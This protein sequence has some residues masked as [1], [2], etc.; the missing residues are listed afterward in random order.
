[1][2]HVSNKMAS[3]CRSKTPNEL[4]IQCTCLIPVGVAVLLV[5]LDV[6][7]MVAVHEVYGV[8]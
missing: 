1:M 5:L 6:L 3:Q 4:R 8:I 7:R 2:L